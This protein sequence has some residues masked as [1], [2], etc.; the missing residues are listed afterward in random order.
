MSFLTLEALNASNTR[1]IKTGERQTLG[2]G[3]MVNFT[4]LPNQPIALVAYNNTG[5]TTPYVVSYNNQAP[6]SFNI[7]SVQGQGFSL[8]NAFFLNPAKTGSR[9]ISVS[10]PNTAQGKASIDVYLVSLFLPTAAIDNIEIPLNGNQ[11]PFDGYSRAYATPPLAWYN[12]NITSTETGLVGFLFNTDS[13]D[14]IAV[15]IASELK[16]QLKLKIYG[17]EEKTGLAPTDPETESGS[18]FSKD[19]YGTSTQYVY[20]PVSSAKTTKNGMISIQKL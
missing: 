11:M 17:D 6:K 18:S 19:I 8:G 12:L 20:S 15:N 5:N 9:E 2:K 14:T 3:D 13:I 4:D 7:D 16:P 1:T 10:V